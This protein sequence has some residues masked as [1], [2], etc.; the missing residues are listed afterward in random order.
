LI[1]LECSESTGKKPVRSR[2]RIQVEDDAIHLMSVTDSSMS[3]R[4][5]ESVYGLGRRFLG[6]VKAVGDGLPGSAGFVVRR[7]EGHG[8][9]GSISR[10]DDVDDSN[11]HYG[12][13]C[14]VN[15]YD[16]IDSV[17]NGD[18]GSVFGGDGAGVCGAHEYAH[19]ADELDQGYF[20]D[21]CVDASDRESTRMIVQSVTRART[22]LPFQLLA[23]NTDI[24][25]LLAARLPSTVKM[26]MLLTHSIWISVPISVWGRHCWDLTI[27]AG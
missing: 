11:R 12:R 8:G 14:L 9:V 22:S 27:P 7:C 25:V 1:W 4:R 16:I 21:G 15:V 17:G 19:A 2:F 3:L 5:R 6:A 23:H 26:S 24:F 13:G 18:A 20:S 10:M